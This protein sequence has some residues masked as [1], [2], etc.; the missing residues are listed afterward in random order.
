[1]SGTNGF[2]GDLWEF[3]RND[4]LNANS[5]QHNLT[6]QPKD[7][8]RWNMFGFAVGGPIIKNK[9]FFFADYQGQR[10]DIPSSAGTDTVFTAAERGADGQFADFGAIC[11]SGFDGS[12]I[13]LDRSKDVAGNNTI[14]TH[15]L[16]NPCASFTAPCTST[17]APAADRTL[18]PF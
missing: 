1:K 15:Q 6:G 11:T 13:C 10:F 2:H 8:I 18:N 4:K 5:W 16:Y 7:K 9:L 17:S 12:G 3:L 14:V